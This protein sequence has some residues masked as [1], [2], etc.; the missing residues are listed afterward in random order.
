MIKQSESSAWKLVCDG[1]FAKLFRD[2][3]A[4]AKAA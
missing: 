4:V 2:K 1:A 3:R